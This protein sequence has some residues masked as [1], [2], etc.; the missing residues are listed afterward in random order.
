M[1]VRIG[2]LEAL[3]R[4]TTLFYEK[5]YAHPWLSKFFVD[6][7]QEHIASQQAE[8][9][10]GVLGGRRI[11]CGRLPGAAHPHIRIT[12]E[13]FDLRQELLRETLVELGVDEE[14]RQRWLILDEA[15]R[16]R[17]VKTIDECEKRYASDIIIAP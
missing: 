13:A 16:G 12:E 9:M 2:G 11:F 14:T 6:V 17:L 1:R 15:F 8:F 7:E 10:Q 4:I 5:V 3:H